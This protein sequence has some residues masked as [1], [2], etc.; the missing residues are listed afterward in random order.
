[1]LQLKTERNADDL[2]LLHP[3]TQLTE[4]PA[5]A[6]LDLAGHTVLLVDDVLY[7][8]QHPLVLAIPRGAVPMAR[9]LARRLDGR[10]VSRKP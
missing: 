7:R 6:D 10:C 2:T 3:D 4:D 1:M 5:L 9:L 8:G